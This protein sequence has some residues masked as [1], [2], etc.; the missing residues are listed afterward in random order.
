MK[1]YLKGLVGLSLL[2][3]LFVV[4]WILISQP[5]LKSNYV[6]SR[7]PTLFF[8]GFG[9][10]Y[11]AEEH[12]V[13]AAESAGVTQT[14]IRALVDKEGQVKLEGNI[15]KGAINP[16]VEVNYEDNRQTDL[17][18]LGSYATAVVKKLQETYGIREMNMVGHSQGNLSIIYYLLANAENQNL[19]QLKKQVSIA[20]H[21]A[22]LEFDG[23]AEEMRLP[24]G[25]TLDEN[26][27]PN[28]MNARYQEMT[29]LR[30]ILPQ[31]QIEVLNL[32]GD[33]G[34]ETDGSV[35]NVSSL[36]LEYLMADKAKTYQTRLFT[37][38]KAQHSQLHENPEVDQALIAFLW[39]QENTKGNR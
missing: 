13:R 29:Q 10:S 11:R 34:G 39:G 16:I 30:D 1:K 15:P 31:G 37:G 33:I 26:G 25:L 12:M 4:A 2:A 9:S 38:D 5:K 28:L 7:R 32:I 3:V 17:K 23:I 35:K 24:E 14:V 36:S 27:K 22:G 21:F 20:G 8:H 19:P 6:Q 18:R